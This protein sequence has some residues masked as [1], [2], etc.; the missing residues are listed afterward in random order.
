MEASVRRA[1]RISDSL[2]AR[3]FWRTP[4]T[5]N[6]KTMA[7]TEPAETAEMRKSRV[8]WLAFTGLQDVAKPMDG[9]DHAG[10]ALR[11]QFA[12]KE[13]DVDLN[14]I[15]ISSRFLIPEFAIDL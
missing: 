9:E 10:L 15:R 11:L 1:R 13:V 12:A 14:K 6:R 7:R 8:L 4:R 2:W 3:T 5:M